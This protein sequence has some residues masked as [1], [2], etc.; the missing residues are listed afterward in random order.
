METKTAW[1]D[2]AALCFCRL[3]KFFFLLFYPL[4]GWWKIFLNATQR[5]RRTLFSYVLCWTLR[6]LK[7]I[8]RSSLFLVRPFVPTLFRCSGLIVC[9]LSFLALYLP[10]LPLSPSCLSFRSCHVTASPILLF[11]W[12]PA[13][14]ML[15]R[16]FLYPF[17]FHLVLHNHL[18]LFW[19]IS[20]SV[21]HTEQDKGY[22]NV[23]MYCYYRVLICARL[24]VTQVWW[25]TPSVFLS[26]FVSLF[27]VLSLFVS[28][29]LLGNIKNT[30][31]LDSKHQ[32][33]HTFWVTAF[34]C[35]KNRA[36]A[37]A[38]VV[39][40]VKPSCKP[41]WIGNQCDISALNAISG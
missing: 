26:F 13:C 19:F 1:I 8:R 39:V 12:Q 25:L 31:P 14:W 30:E 40:T 9:V 38:Q 16:R 22:V 35:G 15:T 27:S 23:Y 5:L 33:V 21:P 24:S 18:P 29:C 11:D 37:D 10:S 17:S 6:V 32:R 7:W 34:D 28:L 4:T 20:L 3:S 2:S 36:Q 41:G